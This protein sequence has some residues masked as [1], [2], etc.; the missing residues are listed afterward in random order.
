MHTIKDAMDRGELDEEEAF[1]VLRFAGRHGYKEAMRRLDTRSRAT[2]LRRWFVT[3][4]GWER[5]HLM[6]WDSGAPA[7]EAKGDP[8]PVSLFGR[9]FVFFGRFEEMRVAGG[10]LVFSRSKCD[11]G[12]RLYWSPDGTPQ[13]ARAVHIWPTRG[14]R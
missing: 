13:H 4:S 14:G 7:F 3:F 10:W 11:G 2:R 1:F 8:T 6:Q 5:P 9:R 12:T